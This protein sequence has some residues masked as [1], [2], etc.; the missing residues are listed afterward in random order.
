MSNPSKK[1]NMKIRVDHDRA[2][3][4]FAVWVREHAASLSIAL[5]LFG[6][7]VSSLGF[8]NVIPGFWTYSLRMILGVFTIGTIVVGFEIVAIERGSVTVPTS[9]SVTETAH[10]SDDES[11]K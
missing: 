1:T 3:G 4:T 2:T 5:V 7:I 11:D 6:M 9:T 10:T 8:F